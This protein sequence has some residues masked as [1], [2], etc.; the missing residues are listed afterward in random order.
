MEQKIK[1]PW[2]GPLWD[3]HVHLFPEK[4]MRSIYRYFR[5]VYR[6]D[7]PFPAEPEPL[8]RRLRISGVSRA[9][10]LAYVHKPDLSRAV[11][12]WLAETAACCRWLVPFGAVDP[13][14]RDLDGVLQEALDNYRFPGLKLHCLVQ[15]YR[16]DDERLFPVYEAL[17]ERNRALVIHAGSFPVPAPERLGWRYIAGLMRRYPALNM[18]LAHLGLDGLVACRA[19]LAEYPGLYLDTAFIF[20]NRQFIPPVDEIR[21]LITDFPERVIYGSDFPF[22]LDQ[23]EYG[24]KRILDL[25]LTADIYRR[26]FYTNAACFLGRLS[27]PSTDEKPLLPPAKEGVEG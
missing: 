26:L 24:I 12:R 5:Q 14:D 8:R 22:I 21:A 17:L 15:P 25:G 9:F 4:L 1:N 23:P 27:M 2:N 10:M 11:N 19:L 3:G 6:W 13:L 20:Q 7:L 18:I 16:P